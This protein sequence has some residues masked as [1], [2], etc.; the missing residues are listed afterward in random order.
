MRVLVTG[1]RGKVGTAAA[2]ELLRAGHEVV[3]TDLGPPVHERELPDEAPYLQADLTDAGAAHALLRDVEAWVHAAA[4]PDPVH[5]APHVV[6][7][8][9]VR[10]DGA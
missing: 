4:I 1:A 9:N 7:T 3:T 8:N 10:P 5:H 2:A 6:F